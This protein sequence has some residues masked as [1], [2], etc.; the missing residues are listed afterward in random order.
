MT[1]KLDVSKAY[2]RVEWPFLR[3]VLLRLGLNSQIIDFIMFCVTSVSYY[4]LLN[5]SHFGLMQPGGEIRQ[6]PL[7]L[8]IF[9]FASLLYR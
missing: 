3:K 5:G 7:S 2:D 9:S 1:L 6:G 8:P 4:F